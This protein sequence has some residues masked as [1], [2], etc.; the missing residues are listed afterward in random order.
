LIEST[1]IAWRP[2]LLRFCS[3]LL[4]HGHDAEEVVQDVFTK[5]L[6]KGAGYDLAEHPEVLLFKMARNRCIDL[7]RKRTPEAMATIEPVARNDQHDAEIASDLAA[8]LATL[9][10]EERE[11]FLLTTVDGLGYR[12]VAAILGCSLGTVASRKYAAIDRLQRRLPR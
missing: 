9:P 5:L 7:R 4:R 2:R 8:A 11:A 10:F 1:F 3:N 6:E 12:E